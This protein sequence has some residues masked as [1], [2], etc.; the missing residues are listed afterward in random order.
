MLAYV[1]R[2][3]VK[4][5]EELDERLRYEAKRR[6]ETISQV[7]RSALEAYLRVGRRRLRAAAAGRSGEAGISERIEQIIGAELSDSAH[8]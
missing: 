2:T 8:R 3:T 4:I 6:G 7:T 1:V 5:P